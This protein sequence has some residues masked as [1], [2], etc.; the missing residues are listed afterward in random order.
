VRVRAFH[1]RRR[2]YTVRLIGI[3][4]PETRRPGT[5]VECGGPQ[6]SASML[7]LAFT[8]PRDLDGDELADADGRHGRRVTLTTDPTQDVFDRCGRLLAYVTTRAGTS[9]Q[10]SQLRRG[11]ARIYVYGGRPFRRASSI[12][13][14]EVLAASAGRGVWRRCGGDVHRAPTVDAAVGTAA[15]AYRFGTVVRDTS[16][17]TVAPV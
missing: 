6:A 8:D 13:H 10:L 7:R 11:W 17:T 16:L 1:A 15:T 4:T 2:F 12:R 3:D 5:P 14:A 9:L